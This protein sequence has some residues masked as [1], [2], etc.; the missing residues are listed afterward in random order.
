MKTVNMKILQLPP[1]QSKWLLSIKSMFRTAFYYDTINIKE[2][3]S[4]IE[5]K[6]IKKDYLDIGLLLNSDDLE[7]FL[8]N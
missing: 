8:K 7:E 5:N 1:E 4:A 2:L 6:A 3:V